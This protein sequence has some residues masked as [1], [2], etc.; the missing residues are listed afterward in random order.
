MLHNAA[1]SSAGSVAAAAAAAASKPAVSAKKIG[2]GMSVES[3]GA[4]AAPILPK[5]M[6]HP[7]AAVRSFVGW[8]SVVRRKTAVKE[9]LASD[10]P[11]RASATAVLA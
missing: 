10:L 4:V 2:S 1:C 3:G 8:R 9:P 5:H 6:P 7:T 11:R